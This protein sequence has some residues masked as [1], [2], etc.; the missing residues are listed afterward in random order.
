MTGGLPPVSSS[1][2]QAPWDSQPA[3]FFQLNTCS[4][5]PSVTSSLMRGW[6]C[7][8]QLL[9][10][11]AIVVIL[12]SESHGTHDH[13]L[14]LR[15][16]VP[17]TWRARSLYLCPPRIGRPSYTSRHW[18]PFSSP[19]T[20]HRAQELRV[21]SQSWSGSYFTTGGLPPISSSWRQ[22]PWDPRPEIFLFQLHS[23]GNSP[24]VTSSLTRRGVCLLWL[25]LAL[26][27]VY[28]SHI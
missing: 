24:Y 17:P 12:S 14:L 25:C 1:W 11:L 20:T 18:G 13:S 2:C 27:Q 5:S 16:Q 9:L 6:V 15:F 19:P 21:K 26:C 3:F 22:A 23:C 28:I 10:A 4:H 8:L 7:H